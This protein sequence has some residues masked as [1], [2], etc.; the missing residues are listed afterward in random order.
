[1][2]AGHY[3]R[4]RRVSSLTAREDVTRL[5]HP[6]LTTRRLAPADK[7]IT[8]LSIELGESESTH[9]TLLG[10]PDAGHI[11]EGIPEPPAVDP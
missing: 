10:G 6:H 3:R 5:V 4:A 8:S 9:P 2:A 7:P 1:M 11:H